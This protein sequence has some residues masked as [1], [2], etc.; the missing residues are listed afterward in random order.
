[1]V[2]RLLAGDEDAE[3]DPGRPEWA[4]RRENEQL[5]K[6]LARLKGQVAAGV[7]ARVRELEAEVERLQGELERIGGKGAGFVDAEATS[8]FWADLGP[9]T[10]TIDSTP[11]DSDVALAEME[12]RARRLGA[13][14]TVQVMGLRAYQRRLL[15]DLDHAEHLLR[16][17][18]EI[19]AGCPMTAADNQGISACLLDLD[20]RLAILEAALGRPEQGLRRAQG[21]LD[22]Y[23]VLGHPG[24]DIDRDGIASCHYARGEIRFELHDFAR[25]AA[26]L[27][28]CLDRYPAE[29]EVWERAQQFFTTALAHTDYAGRKTAFQLQERRRLR[30]S[31]RVGTTEYG[32]F[33]WT[34]GQLA[35]VLGKQ[36]AI[37]KMKLALTTFAG[38]G[39][40]DQVVGIGHDI[41]L[42]MWPNR[43]QI[44]KFFKNELY[45][46]ANGMARD[47]RQVEALNEVVSLLRGCPQPDSSSL[48]A[49]ALR[50]LREAAGANL[51]P[52]LLAAY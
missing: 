38:Q 19:G 33:F 41:A 44:K 24:H 35:V 20:R 45:P 18:F 23:E 49:C 25:C 5:R 12:D 43:T 50:R 30:I 34:D 22:G 31:H 21:A 42:A 40:P 52:C 48:L 32:Y 36:R 13:C 2:K 10:A 29:S 28:V 14:E 17:A 7:D 4:L 39:M 27:S 46:L 3:K 16:K 47:R 15:S 6:E 51:P 26:D 9:L 11:A 1:M 37:K 8:R